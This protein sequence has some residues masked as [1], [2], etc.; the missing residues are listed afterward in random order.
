[1]KTRA[2]A[3]LICIALWCLMTS[4]AVCEDIQPEGIDTALALRVIDL[5]ASERYD[6][7]LAIAD[8][9]LA[10]DPDSPPGYFIRATTLNGR[11]IDYEDD[12]DQA[13]LDEACRKV[14]DICEA[15]LTMSNRAYLH[16]Y[17]GTILGYRSFQ[18]YRQGDWL[19]AYF[20]GVRAAG[21]YESALELDSTYWDACLGLGT[22]NYYRSSRAGLLRKAGLVADRRQRGLDMIRLA[23]ERGRFSRLAARSTLA[24][25]YIERGELGSAIEEARRLL[26]LYPG[27]RAFLW[28]LG[29]A[30]MKAQ[31]WEEATATYGQ[32]LVKVRGESRN[33]HF[34]EV[35]CL[36]ALARA[37]SELGS[38]REVLRVCDEALALK[39]NPEVARRKSDD[40]TH[41]KRLRESVSLKL[42]EG[43]EKVF[44]TDR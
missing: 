1:M 4:T 5:I 31:R 17:L 28:C 37:Y 11:S 30:L 41:L 39:L 2:K 16:F 24:W 12:L 43:S 32:L 18:N 19:S 42:T 40:I 15:M 34:N 10:L 44:I 8:S 21:H 25:I 7:V 22:F 38:W 13:T 9:I 26:E 36:H 35:G 29:S 20:Q 33:N 3:A 23:A 6:D 27:S 14:Q